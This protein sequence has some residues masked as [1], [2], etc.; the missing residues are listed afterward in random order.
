MF[1]SFFR[2]P[3]LASLLAAVMLVCTGAPAEAARKADAKKKSVTVKK[4]SVTVAKKQLRREASV[5]K[6]VKIKTSIRKAAVVVP[7]AP[8]FGQ[9]AGLHLA[10]DPLSLHSSVAFVLDQQ[11]SDV[12]FSKN[13]DAVLP[14][15]SITKL[16]T[17]LVVLDA[18][19]PLGEVLDIS[20]DDVDTERH[21]R[22]RLAVGTQLTRGELMH[23]ALMSSENRA[24][25]ALGRHY[26]GGL[27]AF[28]RA[29]NV[30]AQALGM[31]NSHF[32]DPTGLSSKNVASAGDLARLVSAAH[33]RH[34]I[35][36]YSTANEL[37]VKVGNRML[38][39][40][41][42]NRLVANP[43]WEIGLSK[44]GFINEAGKCLVMQ[45]KIE[46]KTV[47]IVLLDSIGRLGRIGDANRIRNW[48]Q[49]ATARKIS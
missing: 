38:R 2:S 5:R 11:S 33:E 41:N 27:P 8:T 31:H 48:L 10:D 42:T 30:K 26:P 39:Y 1:K 3:V 34:T 12:L 16:M 25:H 40:R 17:A 22:S 15:A 24:A 7:R 21:S 9:R 14:I 32:V 35:R 13:A 6:T 37:D 18:G 47:V 29:M 36:E 4:K 46:G 28:V 49:S 23:L 45:A 44:T 19:L 20:E 43:D